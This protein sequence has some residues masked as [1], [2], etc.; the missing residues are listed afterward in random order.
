[1]L[2]ALCLGLSACTSAS[3]GPAPSTTSDGADENVDESVDD[4]DPTTDD[5]ADQTPPTTATPAIVDNSGASGYSNESSDYLGN[6]IWATGPGNV[7]VSSE[8][9]V[10]VRF[11]ARTSGLVEAAS[12]IIKFDDERPGYQG[13]TCGQLLVTLRPDDDG[14]PSDDVLGSMLFEDPCGGERGIGWLT[15][16]AWVEPVAVTG[17]ETY[18]L[19]F[20]NTD[21]DPANFVSVNMLYRPDED[22][23]PLRVSTGDGVL[24]V[25]ARGSEFWSGNAAGQWGRSDVLADHYPTFE[26]H[27]LE[28]PDQG[29]GTSQGVSYVGARW[30]SEVILA[31]D[32]PTHVRQVFPLER[33]TTVTSLR[34]RGVEASDDA[35]VRATVAT[36]EGTV[37]YTGDLI[38]AAGDAWFGGPLPLPIELTGG[39]TYTVEIEATAGTVEV[40]PLYQA[41]HDDWNS[42][43]QSDWRGSFVEVG[44][45]DVWEGYVSQIPHDL[46]LYFDIESQIESQDETAADN[47]PGDAAPTATVAIY[48]DSL[49]GEPTFDQPLA[50]ALD[51]RNI[52]IV[53]KDNDPGRDI[54]RLV[55][56][57]ADQPMLA[58]VYLINIGINGG[59]S[60]A[61][62]EA[63]ARE[64]VQLIEQINPD[65]QVLWTSTHALESL[66]APFV[67]ERVAPHNAAL[68]TLAAEGLLVVIPW[69][70][71][72]SANPQIYGSDGV[73]F[74][75]NEQL[76]A[77]TM[78]EGIDRL[79]AER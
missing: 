12:F 6:P 70:E 43:D 2:L 8:N 27:Y 24:A 62:F 1:M 19:V 51:A 22:A 28:D 16:Q 69:F 30:G 58:D 61:A 76:Y 65:A 71:V 74:F 52:E 39:V 45:G 37:L 78:V 57:L 11:T 49:L 20:S 53:G 10:A 3:D 44:A 9:E 75:G 77:L 4:A 41:Q 47:E 35:A 46:S 5:G 36:S 33:T 60:E 72:A 79:L 38:R 34:F 42:T 17:G 67:L 40:R 15:D 26:L 23:E 48:G 56:A 66:A 32:N 68:D 21:P 14:A 55:Q 31:P 59:D 54:T 64:A 73:H 63:K 25:L 7:P 50:A 18:H 13:G 29:N